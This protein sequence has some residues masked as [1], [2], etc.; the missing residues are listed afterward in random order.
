[1]DRLL[2][3]KGTRSVDSYH[4]ELGRLLWETCGM[5]RSAAGLESALERIPELRE[6]FW[7]DVRV[8]G[9]GDTLNQS[10]EKAG[11]VADF[12]EFAEVMC[13]DA[14]RRDESCGAHYRA[15]HTTEDGEAKR[16]DDN[17]AHVAVWEFR[18][19]EEPALHREP[20]SFEYVQ[21]SRRSYK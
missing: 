15:E 8:P 9:S 11:R 21:L 18:G 12:M 4:I 1:M 2:S 16:D 10:L 3:I 20:L 17:F 19:A 14:L 5:E 13:H 7:A 6:R